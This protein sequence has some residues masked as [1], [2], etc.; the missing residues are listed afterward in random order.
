MVAVAVV[1]VEAA[2]AWLLVMNVATRLT[3]LLTLVV[4]MSFSIALAILLSDPEA[5]GCMCGGWQAF[6]K[7]T[8]RS[9]AL[10]LV[11]NGI[12]LWTVVWLWTN[13][14]RNAAAAI[15]GRGIPNAIQR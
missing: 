13:A 9:L 4:L 14:R 6:A 11:R 2:L 12:L 1:F 3:L 10:G 8:D 5:P 7:R 15:R